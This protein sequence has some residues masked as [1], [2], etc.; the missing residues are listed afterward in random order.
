MN[1]EEI[2]EVGDLSE[3]EQMAFVV[4]IRLDEGICQICGKQLSYSSPDTHFLHEPNCGYDTVG[5]NCDLPV[6]EECCPGCSR[7]ALAEQI[8]SIDTGRKQNG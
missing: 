2:P 1:M 6:H 8:R 7:D 4:N 5:C 3:S